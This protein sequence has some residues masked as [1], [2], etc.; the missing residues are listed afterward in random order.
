MSKDIQD[1]VR[2]QSINVEFK[3]LEHYVSGKQRNIW[4]HHAASDI[5]NGIAT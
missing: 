1:L 5:E 2:L 4:T 3:S